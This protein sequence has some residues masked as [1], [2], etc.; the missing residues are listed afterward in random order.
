MTAFRP[1]TIEIDRAYVEYMIA[2]QHRNRWQDIGPILQSKA[3]IASFSLEL[4][5]KLDMRYI[6]PALP[7][8]MS[9]NEKTQMAFLNKAP[10]PI[11]TDIP[12]EQPSDPTLSPTSLKRLSEIFKPEKKK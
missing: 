3:D 9:L 4:S 1:T 6:A 2:L 8:N 5:K 7:V 11:A 10:E 12:A